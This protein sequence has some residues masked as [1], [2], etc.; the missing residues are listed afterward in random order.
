MLKYLNAGT[1]LVPPFPPTSLASQGQ[2]G[3]SVNVYSMA[4]V[5]FPEECEPRGFWLKDTQDAKLLVLIL[6]CFF[7]FVF[8]F[9]FCFF[10][11]KEQVDTHNM[12][13]GGLFLLSVESHSEK[14]VML[15]FIDTARSYMRY[16]CVT[17]WGSYVCLVLFST[18]KYLSR[19]NMGCME[20]SSSRFWK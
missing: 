4:G 13:F 20:T 10:L 7:L 5:G 17:E 2:N 18:Y 3:F 16:V 14:E 11:Q 12:F 19:K 6:W 1:V 9:C 15:A 8:W